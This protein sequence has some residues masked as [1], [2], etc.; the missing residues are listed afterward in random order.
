[1][2]RWFAE[3]GS[4]KKD[5]KGDLQKMKKRKIWLLAVLSFAMLAISACGSKNNSDL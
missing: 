5:D 4:R 1:M 3:F 2:Q